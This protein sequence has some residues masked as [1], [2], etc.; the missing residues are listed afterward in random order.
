MAF[1]ITERKEAEAKLDQAHS[2]LISISRQ[3]GMAEVATSVLHNV[4]NVLT[5]VNIAAGLISE[6]LKQSKVTGVGLV[7]A[8]MRNHAANLGEFITS[9]PKGRQIPGYLQELAEFLATEQATLVK[10]ADLV[11]KHIEHIND[12]VSMQQ[13]YAKVS[14]V[15]EIVKVTEL[16][17]DALRM[18]SGALSRHDVRIKREFNEHVPQI[19]VDKH[20][21]LQIL[22]NLIRNA[23][24]ACDE[25][26]HQ[27]KNLVVRV[28]NGDDRV[29]IA[30]IDNGVG[31]PPENMTLIFRH[32]FTTRKN[33]HGFGLHSG[34]LAAKEMGGALT[35]RSDGPGKGATF[36][37]ELPLQA[38]K[39]TA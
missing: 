22:V 29:R 17:E 35:A 7:A 39:P 11:R 32:G 26:G 34:A 30:V 12:I 20:K 18:N 3:A 36:I 10:E 16:V 8:A 38:Q 2:E 25:S 28:T 9:D 5:S 23:K 15:T 24:Y 37:L 31:I 19:I 27:E 4:G 33:G 1:D 21:V 6:R 14:G 13:A